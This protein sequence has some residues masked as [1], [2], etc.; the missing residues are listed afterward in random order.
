MGKSG[1]AFHIVLKW[2][3]TLDYDII[4]ITEPKDILMYAEC[5]KQKSK[6]FVANLSSIN[7]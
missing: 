1:H 5:D 4:S 2:G 3:E 6:I 7:V